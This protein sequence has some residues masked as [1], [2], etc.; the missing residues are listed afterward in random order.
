MPSRL[1][2]TALAPGKIDTGPVVLPSQ[3]FGAVAATAGSAPGNGTASLLARLPTSIV[4][5][6]RLVDIRSGVADAL[7]GTGSTPT[8][9]LLESAAVSAIRAAASHDGLARPQ[10]PADITTLRVRAL[11]ASLCP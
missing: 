2:P 6:G 4:R 1:V 3:T 10:T 7:G 11:T 8:V 5:N 9:R